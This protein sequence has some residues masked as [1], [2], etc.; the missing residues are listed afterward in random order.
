[1][2]NDAEA[3]NLAHSGGLFIY[4]FAKNERNNINDKELK[5]LREIAAAWLAASAQNIEREV[6]DGRLQEVPND[7]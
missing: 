2:G 1:M 7:R 3:P 4:G 6:A 5:T